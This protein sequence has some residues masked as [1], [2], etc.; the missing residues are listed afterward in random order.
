MH[1][2]CFE[3]LDRSMRDKMKVLNP[4]RA[5]ILFGGKTIVFGGDFRQILPVIPKESRQDIV[6][7]TI[8]SLYLWKDCTILR[9]T[10]NMRLQNIGTNESCEE[11]KLFA[12]WIAKIGDGKIA[13]PNDGCAK[14]DIPDDFLVKEFN[15][16]IATIVQS[17]SPT[18]GSNND[19]SSYF[20]ER[21]VLASTLDVVHS[22]NDYMVSKNNSVGRTYLSS[23]SPCHSDRNVDLL[24]DVHTPEFLNEINVLE[25]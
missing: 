4:S 12:D 9:L 17:T 14:I 20:E 18:F 10:K 19:D 15:D 7:A 16:P 6:H 24:N 21:A 5:N 8:N 3:A 23:D 1:K 13:E 2:Y 25:F 11:L 22:I